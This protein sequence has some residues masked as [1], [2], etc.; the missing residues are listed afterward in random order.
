MG[1][2]SAKGEQHCVRP[3][4]DGVDV[5]AYVWVDHYRVANGVEIEVG[6]EYLE[7]RGHEGVVPEKECESKLST[8]NRVVR[9]HD[10][11]QCR[12]E[13]YEGTEQGD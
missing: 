2:Q 3:G 9:R 8:E 10:S 1:H 5:R 7:V 11:N 6:R 13:R 12:G 4:P